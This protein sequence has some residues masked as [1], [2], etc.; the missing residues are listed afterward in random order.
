MSN[1]DDLRKEIKE[2]DESL[3]MLLERRFDLA[4]QVGDFKRENGLPVEDPKVEA[5]KRKNWEGSDVGEVFEMIMKVARKLQR[6]DNKDMPRKDFGDAKEV[7]VAIMGEEGSFSEEA[8]HQYLKEG[9]Y[10]NYQM[11]YPISAKEVLESLQSGES[12]FGVF[13]IYNAVGGM[14]EE[15]IYAMAES[16]FVLQ[17]MFMFE[18]K[19]QLMALPGTKMESVQRV[20]SHAHAL[21]QCK[22]FLEEN[23]A[24]K[25][26]VSSND[27]AGAARIL[28]LRK[29]D[30]GGTAVIAPR[31]CAELYGLEILAEDIQDMDKNETTFVV[32]RKV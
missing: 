2:I 27:T 16:K 5:M 22:T 30:Y 6:R 14:V 15:A 8:A 25:E 9:N 32:A 17:D 11:V 3:M 10:Q 31:A 28:S 20:M 7:T 29:D 13:P 1:L 23:F 12:D 26:I 18:V 4:R 19:Q 24:G 21:D